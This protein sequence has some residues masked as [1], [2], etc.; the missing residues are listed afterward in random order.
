[1]SIDRRI[2]D[3]EARQPPDRCADPF[4]RRPFD[5]QEAIAA[6]APDPPPAPAC[7]TCGGPRGVIQI[8]TYDGYAGEGPW[9]T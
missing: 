8:I 4:H 9:Q 6:I 2:R 5:F 1:M 7:P 3:L